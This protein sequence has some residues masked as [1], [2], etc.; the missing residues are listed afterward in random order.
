MV[1]HEVLLIISAPPSMI[2]PIFFIIC[3]FFCK[4]TVVCVNRMG[5]RHFFVFL[6]MKNVYRVCGLFQE[7]NLGHF[8]KI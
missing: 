7:I 2:K 5:I 1:T 6:Y 8:L 3:K 4:D